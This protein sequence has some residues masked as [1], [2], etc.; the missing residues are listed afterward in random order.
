[1][2]NRERH[3]GRIATSIAG[4]DELSVDLGAVLRRLIL[5]EHCK[6]ESIQ[7]RE[8]PH[9]ISI[10]G[11]EGLIELLD[12]GCIDFVCDAQTAAQAGQNTV[13]KAADIRGGPL[14]L[15]SYRLVT[16]GLIQDGPDREE[17]IHN[18]LQEVHK[19]PIS[20]KR[21]QKV[22]SALLSQIGT[23]PL[24]SIHA[25]TTD[26]HK[27]I[28]RNSSFIWEAIRFAAFSDLNV[29][30]GR[31]PDFNAEDLGNEGDLRIATNLA[32]KYGLSIE[33]E[34][35]LVQKGILAAVGVNQ[36]IR[37]MEGFD[38]VTGFQSQ[39][40]PLFDEKLSSILRQI[41]PEQQEVHFERVVTIAG[42][43]GIEDLLSAD[44][45]ID[46]KRLLKVRESPECKEL[47]DWIRNVDAQTDAEIESQFESVRS[48]LAS[49]VESRAGKSVRFL[50]TTG[51]AFVPAIGPVVSPLLSAGDEFLLEKVI[52]KPGPATF[53]NKSYRSIFET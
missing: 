47:R 15:G 49:V 33:Q 46:V 2:D 17:Y 36:K 42:L 5:F 30:I 16:I 13:L 43:P 24:E 50:L 32:A 8:L 40:L 4:S 38:A 29:D 19:A 12:S 28:L 51:S 6:V 3:Y 44:R 39:E 37:L 35:N 25:A 41:D 18:A 21:A 45:T 9:L 22:K 26:T 27:E 1:M 10:F 7:L 53:L 23:Y 52:G 31:T 20:L 34:H 48:R 14:P 11:A